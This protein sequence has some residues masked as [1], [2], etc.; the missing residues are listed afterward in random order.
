MCRSSSPRPGLPRGGPGRCRQDRASLQLG[1]DLGGADRLGAFV[2][3]SFLGHT[4]GQRSCRRERG[5]LGAPIRG[6]ESADSPSVDELWNAL[7]G[8]QKARR[9]RSFRAGAQSAP[10]EGRFGPS[11]Y[12][13]RTVIGAPPTDPANNSATTGAPC[14]CGRSRTSRWLGIRASY[15]RTR[16]P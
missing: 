12:W 16:R 13:R 5:S 6:Q 9:T 3:A 10:A 11:M 15:D 4:A 8:D 1:A 14:S 7:R 2:H